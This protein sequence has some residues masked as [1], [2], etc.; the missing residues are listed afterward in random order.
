MQVLPFILSLQRNH[1]NGCINQGRWLWWYGFSAHLLVCYA[2]C[3]WDSLSIGLFSFNIQDL[4]RKLFFFFNIYHTTIKNYYPRT[5][6]GGGG[7]KPSTCLYNKGSHG[8]AMKG[9]LLTVYC[10][11]FTVLLRYRTVHIFICDLYMCIP[12]Q[13]HHWY[14]WEPTRK[15][16]GY[17]GQV[18]TWMC[19][20]ASGCGY[21]G[22]SIFCGISI[23]ITDGLLLIWPPGHLQLHCSPSSDGC[24]YIRWNEWF[25]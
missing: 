16:L 13:D 1:L 2:M 21:E 9:C 4:Y 6:G 19:L 15:Y 7:G 3:L 23:M 25:C 17:N 24:N 22:V 14:L 12:C 20:C 10:R 11:Y 18:C 8:Q 5:G